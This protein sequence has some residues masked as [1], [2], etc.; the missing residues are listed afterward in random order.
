MSGVYM[1]D[2][3]GNLKFIFFQFGGILLGLICE[4]QAINWMKMRYGCTYFKL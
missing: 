4:R 2:R 3:K 1:D